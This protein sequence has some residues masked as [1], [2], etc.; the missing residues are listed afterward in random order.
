MSTKNNSDNFQEPHSSSTE[1]GQNHLTT[2]QE[3]GQ[4]HPT[5]SQEI[6]QHHPT[7]WQEIGQDHCKPW[8]EIGQDHCKPCQEIGQNHP[9]TC[10]SSP[11]PPDPAYPTGSTKVLYDGIY[12]FLCPHCNLVVAVEKNEVNCRI[13]RHGNYIT[14]RDKCGRPIGYGESINPHTPKNICDDL[15][16]RNQIIGCGKPLQMYVSSESYVS[17]ECQYYVRICDYI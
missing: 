10:Q 7:T 11:Y 9:T 16:S 6:G 12:T 13:F 14:Q 8:Q 1:I 17:S 2:C 5:T 15:V 4:N 3:I